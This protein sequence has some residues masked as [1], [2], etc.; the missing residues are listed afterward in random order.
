MSLKKTECNN[1]LPSVV[2]ESRLQ[3]MILAYSD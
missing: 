2:I 1:P 3:Q